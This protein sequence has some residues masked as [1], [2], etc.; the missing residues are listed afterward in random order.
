[1]FQAKMLWYVVKYINCSRMFMYRLFLNI[2]TTNLSIQERVVLFCFDL[3]LPNDFQ[4]KPVDGEVEQF[5]LYNIEQVLSMM[6]KDYPDPMKPNCYM[7]VIDFLIRH[8]FV[9]PDVPG[10]LDLVRELRTGCC[11]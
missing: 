4:P 6:A 10:Y 1:M 5:Y 9:S 8:G 3:Y 7:V 11:Q 2:S